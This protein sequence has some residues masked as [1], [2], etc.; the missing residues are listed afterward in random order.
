MIEQE[1]L[2]DIGKRQFDVSNISIKRRRIATRKWNKLFNI[3]VDKDGEAITDE[4]GNIVEVEKKK[5]LTEKQATRELLKIS[6]YL[7]QQDFIVLNRR[8]K[9]TEAI[10]EFF[11]RHFLTV[12]YIESL[13]LDQMNDLVSW[14][15]E[16]M[17][18]TK[19]KVVDL[20]APMI[21]HLEKMIEG[22]TDQEVQ[23]LTTFFMTAFLDQVGHY[24]KYVATQKG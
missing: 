11:K 4:N 12:K 22:K 10:I 18:G 20:L 13:T 8:F 1:E 6:I 9:F 2:I 16:K 17:T 7:I 3:S 19:K 15:Y 14:T 5:K 21:N 24:E 23:N